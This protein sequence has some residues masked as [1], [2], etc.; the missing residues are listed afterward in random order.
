MQLS[1]LSSLVI[2]CWL[3]HISHIVLVFVS[4]NMRPPHHPL[5]LSLIIP[6]HCCHPSSSSS[7]H[8]NDWPVIIPRPLPQ[9]DFFAPHC[10]RW[11]PSSHDFLIDCCINIVVPHFPLLL[12]S[13]MPIVHHLVIDYCKIICFSLPLVF[14]LFVPRRHRCR[15]DWS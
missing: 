6:C 5:S 15:C 10:P 2:H 14:L 7:F 4:D 9:I 8:V 3:F 13:L 11:R 1:L 12:S